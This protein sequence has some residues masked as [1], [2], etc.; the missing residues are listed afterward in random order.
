MQ[1]IENT[2]QHDRCPLCGNH[3]I[4]SL[5]EILYQKPVYFSTTPVELANNAV[6]YKCD[7]CMSG[8]IQGSIPEQIAMSLY[9]GGASNDRWKAIPF[10]NAKTPDILNALSKVFSPG[11]HV[12]D[13]GCN[14]GELLDFAK[15]NG[16]ITFGNEPSLESQKVLL[17]KG[18]KVCPRLAEVEDG[19]MDVIT[20]FDL[21]EHLYDV[22]GFL[23]LCKS[24][25]S[26]NG[27][28]VILTGDI[29]S[30][31]ARWAG[32]NWWYLKYPEHVVFPAPRFYE[33]NGFL[34]EELLATYASVGFK[35]PL[36]AAFIVLAKS[37]IGA[38][39]KRRK[40]SSYIGLPSWGP[41]HYLAII[42]NAG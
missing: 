14:T 40:K 9:A 16:C 28:M 10:R 37:K 18:H 17:S 13:V 25:L 38:L 32:N 5:G 36:F 24:K 4:K 8:F 11:S 35:K 34:L 21:I 42:K 1:I 22:P 2:I 31:S 6:L 33:R 3:E 41:D 20:A 27:R 7:A 19:S 12:L 30:Q 23:A 15:E 26:K 29:N 39:V